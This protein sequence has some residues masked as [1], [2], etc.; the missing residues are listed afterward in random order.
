MNIFDI[1][2]ILIILLSGVVGLKRGVLKELVM[3]IGTIIVYVI[4]FQLKNPLA[5]LMMHY[6][7][8]FD[9]LGKLKGVIVLN[10]VLYQVLS[11]AIISSILLMVFNAILKVTGIIQKLID[12]TIILTLPSKILGFIVG[13]ISGY[14]Y[15]FIALII[16]AVPLGGIDS[17]TQSNLVNRILYDS[18]VLSNSLGGFKDAVKD[19]YTLTDKTVTS[20]EVNTTQL[21]LDVMNILLKY[22]VIS[23]SDMEKLLDNTNKLDHI[24]GISELI[25]QYK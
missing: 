11:F 3:L 14:L 4:A 10:V 25:Y 1:I 7:P 13:L 22:K 16:F 15:V 8:F 19:I 23:S 6:L 18:P 12:L 2:I 20:E 5:N 17:F 21:N 9:F 24:T